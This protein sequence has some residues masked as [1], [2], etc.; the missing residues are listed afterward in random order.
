[1]LEVKR[2]GEML[3]DAG[4][5]D[6]FQLDSA[7]SM[8]HNL[9]GRI[10][11]ALVKLGYV[12]EETIME[13]LEMQIKYGHVV[14]AEIEIS[15]ELMQLLPPELMLKML[16]V[17]LELRKSGGEKTLRV[18]MLDPNNM[19]QIDALQFKTGCR[20][21]PVVVAADEIE[22]VIRRHLPQPEPEGVQASA[23]AVDHNL[24][25][26]DSLAS[27]DSKFERLMELLQSKGVL[28]ALEVERIKFG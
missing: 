6:Q 10:G 18:A 11:S 25:D 14:L 19:E 4:L 8:Q 22:D 17:P 7:L 3:L 24:V 27:A 20:I 23:V 13:F 26:F 15:E 9:G 1:M 21:L 28:S 16:V 12:P 2:L 5:I